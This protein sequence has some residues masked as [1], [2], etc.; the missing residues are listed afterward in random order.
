DSP[1]SNGPS[2][3]F[4]G[5]F[6]LLK[7][8]GLGMGAMLLWYEVDKYNP[9]LQSFCSGG[10]KVNC[11]S[12]LNSKYAKVFNGKLSLGSI[13]FSY[14]FGTFFYL[15]I[16]GFSETSLAPLAFLSFA[17]LPIVALSAFYQGV[18]IKQWCKFCIAVQAV[19]LMEGMTAFLGGFHLFGM[20]FG[21]LTLL[22]ALLL[23]PIPLWKWLRPM[24][25]GKKAINLHRRGLKKIKNNPDVFLGLLS[26]TRKT[27]KD[28][29]AL[30]ITF[31][32]KSAKYNVLKVCNP[33]CGPCASAHP[34]L[35]ELVKANKINLQI[36]F[37]AT[38]DENDFRA[39]P[40]RHFLALDTKGDE[41]G[42]QR[43]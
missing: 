8:V 29:N 20:E 11:D 21:P 28:T 36:L 16:N 31:R 5:C 17:A 1:Y 39:K 15:L 19:L 33:Y 24:L 10:K 9:T 25:E 23:I 42:T 37:T 41:K 12:V 2:S 22:L 40:V 6:A 30:G 38:A 4:L 26:K 14:F 43:A 7:L 3:W 27:T 32:N 35:D 18:A 13:G 34:I